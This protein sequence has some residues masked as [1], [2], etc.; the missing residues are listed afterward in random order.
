[1]TTDKYN[2]FHTGVLRSVQFDQDEY[3]GRH[4]IKLIGRFEI[5]TSADENNNFVGKTETWFASLSEEVTGGKTGKTWYEFTVDGLR[6]CGWEG[7]SLAELP[8]LAESGQ[9]STEVKLTVEHRGKQNEQTGVYEWKTS[10]AWVNPI[11]GGKIKLKNELAGDA[12]TRFSKQME[13]RI[14]ALAGG[15]QRQGGQQ[16][17]RSAAPPARSSY[18]G[19]GGGHPN[20]PGGGYRDEPRRSAPDDDIP[21][22]TCALAHEP[23]AIAPV[24][25]R[26]T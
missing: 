22:A 2:S 20:A 25:R 23:T 21:F 7:T 15:G 24:L 1:M 8:A 13:G 14:A 4:Y 10:I 5:L 16:Q 12:L 19:N 26:A 18:G 11:G 6:A 17:T 9:L 3:Q